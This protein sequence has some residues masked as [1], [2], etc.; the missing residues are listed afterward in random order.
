MDFF[1]TAKKKAAELGANAI[2][3]TGRVVR[4]AG[5]VASGST[6]NDQEEE[7]LDEWVDHCVCMCVFGIAKP[8]KLDCMFLSS[9]CVVLDS[10]LL[11]DCCKVGAE[12]YNV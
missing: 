1:N 7:T 8:D 10:D 6:S 3:A 2:Y 4:K 12:C 11:V 5:V 9:T